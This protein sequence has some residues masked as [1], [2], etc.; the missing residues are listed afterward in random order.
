MASEVPGILEYCA[1]TRK[2]RRCYTP[3]LANQ[4]VWTNALTYSALQLFDVFIKVVFIVI[5]LV[6]AVGI[7]DE[8]KY[9]LNSYRIS[10]HFF[11]RHLSDRRGAFLKSA[12]QATKETTEEI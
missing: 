9:R 8:G 2:P 7:V 5:I 3:G 11:E 10:L 12:I 6:F 4:H 1:H